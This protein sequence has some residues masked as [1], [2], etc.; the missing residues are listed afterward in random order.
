MS[1]LEWALSSMTGVY[2]KRKCGH[3]GTPGICTHRGKSMWGQSEKAAICKPMR[4]ASEE[5]KSADT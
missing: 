2:K 4:D 3:I 5:M 1:L